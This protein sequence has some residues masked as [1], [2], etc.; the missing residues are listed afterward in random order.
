MMLLALALRYPGPRQPWYP[1]QT[2]TAGYL[3][4]GARR[5]SQ[6]T[7]IAASCGSFSNN[8]DDV[9]PRSEN[10]SEGRDN[11][12]E[13][14]DSYRWQGWE[15]CQPWY[16]LTRCFHCLSPRFPLPVA[17]IRLSA[18]LQ[19]LCSSLSLAPLHGLWRNNSPKSDMPSYLQAGWVLP[20]AGVSFPQPSCFLGNW[21]VFKQIDRESGWK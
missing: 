21:V 11:R 15:G 4:I 12:T 13:Y 18:Y 7:L 19:I 5:W 9:L 1:G 10:R 2:R 6:N 16:H 14:E 3:V 17:L 8:K 20:S